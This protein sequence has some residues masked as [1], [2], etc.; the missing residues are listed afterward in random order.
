[1]ETKHFYQKSKFAKFL[2]A[3]LLFLVYLVSF[4]LFIYFCI[5]KVKLLGFFCE[6]VVNPTVVNG[7]IRLILFFIVFLNI[8]ANLV[9][10]H[11][12]SDAF[13]YFKI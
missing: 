1:M 12:Q 11:L 9:V 2:L 4:I 10:L 5:F 13:L 6:S 3:T 8:I 7:K